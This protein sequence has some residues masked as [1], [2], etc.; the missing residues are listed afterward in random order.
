MRRRVPLTNLNP[1]DHRAPVPSGAGMGAAAVSPALPPVSRSEEEGKAL[2]WTPATDETAAI[3]V[4]KK[5]GWPKGK[6]RG[7]K[8]A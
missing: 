8:H 2:I 7:P 4:K 3:Q 5:A 1:R 6:K